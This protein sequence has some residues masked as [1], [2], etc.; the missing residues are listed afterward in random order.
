MPSRVFSDLDH[1]YIELP[2]HIADMPVLVALGPNGEQ[3]RV[4]YRIRNNYVIV[5]GVPDALALVDGTGSSDKVTIS[6]GANR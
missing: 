6:R 4:N 2:T 5:D 1:V 3:E